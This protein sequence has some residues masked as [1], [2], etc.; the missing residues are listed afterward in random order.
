[1]IKDPYVQQVSTLPRVKEFLA[2][3]DAKKTRDTYRSS[4]VKLNGYLETKYDDS[5]SNCETIID[6]LHKQKI[7]VYD[8][9]HGFI[10]YLP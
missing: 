6:S 3:Y 10:S 9:L 1:L 4:L 5:N 8:L 7:D 2:K